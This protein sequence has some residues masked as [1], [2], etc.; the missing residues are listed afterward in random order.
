[1]YGN[2]HDSG[3]IGVVYKYHRGFVAIL[4]ILQEC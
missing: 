2:L 3:N 1:M 4:Y